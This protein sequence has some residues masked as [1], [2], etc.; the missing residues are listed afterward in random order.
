MYSLSCKDMGGSDCD[1]V[2][3][4][5]TADEVVKAMGEHAM[6]AHPDKVKE[7]S[8]GMTPEQMAEK[9]KAAVKTV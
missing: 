3:T 6:Q 5:A 7:M 4:G 9:M 1:F 8:E 2:V